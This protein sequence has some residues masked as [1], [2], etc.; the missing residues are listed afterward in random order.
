MIPRAW[1]EQL[2]FSDGSTLHLGRSD[3][4][5]IVGPNNAGKSASLRAIRDKLAS[6]SSSPVITGLS[7]GR[8][9]NSDEVVEWLDSFARKH[10]PLVPDP[11]FQ[12]LGAGVHSSQARS[13]WQGAGTTL[14]GL[15]RFFCHLLTADERLQAANPASAIAIVREPPLLPILNRYRPI[16]STA[17]VTSRPPS[18]V[19]R[20]LRA[21]SIR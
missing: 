12:A 5:V 14:H 7:M 15:S 17:G 19:C 16:G 13:F 1:V 3:I 10:D 21:T 8:E 4:I 2:T 20:P 9:G 6:D 18:S 11:V